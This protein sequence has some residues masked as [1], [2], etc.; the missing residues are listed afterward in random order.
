MKQPEHDKLLYDRIKE[1]WDAWN[2]GSDTF[3]S[4]Y[5]EIVDVIKGYLI[6]YYRLEPQHMQPAFDFFLKQI[7][8]WENGE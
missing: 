7:D 4:S 2:T 1:L 5:D 3:L 6:C 8:L